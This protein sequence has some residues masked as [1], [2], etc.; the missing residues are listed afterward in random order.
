MMI[1]ETFTTKVELDRA[2]QGIRVTY[3][4]WSVQASRKSLDLPAAQRDGGTDVRFFIDYEFKSRTF[5]MLAG[6]VFEMVFR[7][8]GGGL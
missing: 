4:R 3:G 1:R 2:N 5:Q 7:K 8:N 6:A